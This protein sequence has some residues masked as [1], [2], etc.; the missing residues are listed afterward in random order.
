MAQI[1]FGNVTKEKFHHMLMEPLYYGYLS[2]GVFPHASPMFVTILCAR[3]DQ[4]D[5]S[6]ICKWHPCVVAICVCV[7]ASS[8]FSW[9]YDKTL[10]LGFSF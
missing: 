4:E 1:K 5:V 7:C 6:A 2:A 3:S 9:V 8:C 10:L